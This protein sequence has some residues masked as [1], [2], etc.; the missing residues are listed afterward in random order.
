MHHVTVPFPVEV[1]HLL[2][3]APHKP[4]HAALVGA[5]PVFLTWP[6]IPFTPMRMLLGC[7]DIRK[8]SLSLRLDIGLSFFDAKFGLSKGYR[9]SACYGWVS[10]NRKQV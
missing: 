5:S 1:L 8:L 7:R 4:V 2:V 3:R 10:T 9:K 6:H